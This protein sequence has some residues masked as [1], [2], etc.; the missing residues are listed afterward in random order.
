MC[1]TRYPTKNT[2][3]TA[4]KLS[5]GILCAFLLLQGRSAQA[6]S[7]E[8]FGLG[9]RWAGMGDAVVGLA[10]DFAAAFYN[11]ANT[12][13]ADAPGLSFGILGY[14]ARLDIG[15]DKVSI[16]HPIEAQAG[17]HFPI[18]FKGW[19][20]RRL[21]VAVAFSSHPD[22]AARLRGY[23]PTD[24]FYPFYDNRTQRLL[25][26]PSLSFKAMDHVSYG[27]LSLGL[28]V[29]SLA[30]LKGTVV[31]MEGPSRSMEARVEEKLYSVLRLIA[32]VTYEHSGFR[33]AA[34]YRQE[35]KVTMSTRSHN[36]VAGTD[37]DL[38]IEADTLYDPHVFVLGAAWQ[39]GEKVG[40][41]WSVALELGYSLWSLY[42]GPY[43]EV[44]SLLPLVGDLR[45][46][47]PNIRFNNTISVRVG[48]EKWFLLPRTLRLALR[49]GFGFE[50]TPVPVQRGRTNMLDGHKLAFSLGM[51]IDLG[52]VLSRRVRL[53]AQTRIET[54]LS[55]TMKKRLYFP[56]EECPAPPAG[57]VSPDDYLLDE[58]P[59]DRTDPATLG[60]QTSNPGY[61]SIRSGGFVFSG[62]ITLG[63]EL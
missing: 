38:D 28:G 26:I 59:C 37:L 47:L 53:D 56:E 34:A 48:L 24:A 1:P 31:G 42:K 11:P 49:G 55:R 19:M 32:G 2:V 35:M 61:P 21:W 12:A 7:A 22:I 23:M 58:L 17:V 36:H 10:D 18:P 29:N 14:G 5:I 50:N 39:T 33:V 13:L 41:M 51:G 46:D 54:V 43:V 3:P 15:N 44:D 9:S 45:G 63:V 16:Q 62:S 27:K 25:L 30:G 57:E 6:V 20:H 60:F 8:I 52:K 4:A 40:D